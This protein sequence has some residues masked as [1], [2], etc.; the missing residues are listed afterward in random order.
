LY[1]LT[2]SYFRIEI[3]AFG[4]VFGL[5]FQS[6]ILPCLGFYEGLYRTGQWLSS[7]VFSHFLM[8]G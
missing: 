3:Y 5:G 6:L 4:V 1:N 2:A 8:V 7:D